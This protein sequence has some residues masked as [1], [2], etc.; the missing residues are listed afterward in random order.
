MNDQ[1]TERPKLG[2]AAMTDEQRVREVFKNA[3]ACEV[4]GGNEHWWFI[5]A[6]DTP[7]LRCDTILSDDETSEAEAWADAAKR[8]EEQRK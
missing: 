6:G 5:T 2:T 3:H 1:Q 7:I 8:V 4:T